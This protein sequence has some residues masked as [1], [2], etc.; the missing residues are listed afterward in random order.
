VYVQGR[1]TLFDIARGCVV[2]EE[3]DGDGDGEG[4]GEG[5]GEG[6]GEERVTMEGGDDVKGVKLLIESSLGGENDYKVQVK[7]EVEKEVGRKVEEEDKD[8]GTLYLLVDSLFLLEELAMPSSLP[9]IPSPAPAPPSIPPSPSTPSPSP[10]SLLSPTSLSPSL[11]TGRS[12]SVSSL[13]NTSSTHTAT[14][15]DNGIGNGNGIGSEGTDI[16]YSIS[17]PITALSPVTSHS[18]VHSIPITNSVTVTVDTVGTVTVTV[19]SSSSNGNGITSDVPFALES[20]TINQGIENFKKD[21]QGEGKEKKKNKLITVTIPAKKENENINTQISSITITESITDKTDLAGNTVKLEGGLVAGKKSSK[22]K[23]KER[24]EGVDYME[25]GLPRKNLNL[26]DDI[27]TLENMI[28]EMQDEI[29]D[30]IDKEVEMEEMEVNSVITSNTLEDKND[31]NNQNNNKNNNKNDTKNEKKDKKEL[32]ENTSDKMN[33]NEL[34]ANQRSSLS[35]TLRVVGFDCEWRPEHYFERKLVFSSAGK[36]DLNG[37]NKTNIGGEGVFESVDAQHI[38][39]DGDGSVGGGGVCDDDSKGV[40]TISSD[41]SLNSHDSNNNKLSKN[42]DVTENLKTDKNKKQKNDE[43][44]NGKRKLIS[45]M[46]KKNR[47]STKRKEMIKDIDNDFQDMVLVSEYSEI[48]AKI[49]EIDRIENRIKARSDLRKLAADSDNLMSIKSHIDVDFLGT[50]DEKIN[51]RIEEDFISDN[52]EDNKFID[53]NIN[54]DE[55]DDNESKDDILRTN[56]TSWGRFDVP[57]ERR[58]RDQN[59]KGTGTGTGP[60]P[61]RMASPVMLLQVD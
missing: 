56:N 23:K 1:G 44:I 27:V 59:S 18:Q 47:G 32:K 7:E 45:P 17:S 9:Y 42:E 21:K 29:F 35:A 31:Q 28:K 5:E 43:E 51:N 4:E 61:A 55:N 33:N 36:S 14:D 37:Q 52:N 60:G 40:D 11:S 54:N 39:S 53:E 48:A 3:G 15:T 13:D 34:P 19:I 38:S 20:T 50:V 41:V 16:S 46:G 25:F 22:K 6:K 10:T 24:V 49:L 26:V 12:Q 57:R 30:D 8:E 2:G 58:R